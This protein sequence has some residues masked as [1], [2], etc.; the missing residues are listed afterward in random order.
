MIPLANDAD[1]GL[2]SIWGEDLCNAS[3]I[4][5]AV[6][7]FSY[8]GR[9]EG[10]LGLV[11]VHPGAGKPISVWITA[12]NEDGSGTKI[13]ANR[14]WVGRQAS[15]QPQVLASGLQEPIDV[16]LGI[17]FDGST[18]RAIVGNVE[19]DLG[20][21]VIAFGDAQWFNVLYR[22]PP[23]SELTAHID[24][25]RVVP[26]DASGTTNCLLPTITPAPEG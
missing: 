16:V 15:G 18:A 14:E 6:S 26:S 7:G 17:R 21:P 4:Q 13:I 25:V 3:E 23:G 22:S 20:N 9:G 5:V 19:A 11:A 24:E 2:G 8:Q 12:N 10:W 1:D